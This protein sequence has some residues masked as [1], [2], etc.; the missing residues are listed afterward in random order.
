MEEIL[1]ESL[2]LVAG[3]LVYL[4]V[5]AYRWGLPWVTHTPD[6]EEAGRGGTGPSGDTNT[7]NLI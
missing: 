7:T 1:R 6:Q 3:A 4:G 2:G 5:G